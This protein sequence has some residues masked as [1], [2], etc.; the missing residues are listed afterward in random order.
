MAAWLM[1]VTKSSVNGNRRHT[2]RSGDSISS[3]AAK[4]NV[5]TQ[6]LFNANRHVLGASGLTYG[7]RL[8][9]P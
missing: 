8:H 5:S 2:V 7:M 4:Y 1:S 9:L 6:A 3:I